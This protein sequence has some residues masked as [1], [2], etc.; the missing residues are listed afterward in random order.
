MRILLIVVAVFLASCGGEPVARNTGVYMLLDT[1]GTYRAE[2]EKA[3]QIIYYT[4]SRLGPAD[5]FAVARI[6]TGSAEC[7][8]VGEILRPIPFVEQGRPVADDLVEHLLGRNPSRLEI[9]RP[10]IAP[11]HPRTRR[12]SGVGFGELPSERHVVRNVEQVCTEEQRAGT[13]EVRVP[14][15]E[16][17]CHKR[18]VQVHPID[19]GPHGGQDVVLR[20]DGED[21]PASKRYRIR[22]WR[23]GVAG[24]QAT[25]DE[26]AHPFVGT[27]LCGCG[28]QGPT[29][30]D[31]GDDG[32]QYSLTERDHGTLAIL[33]ELLP[34][35]ACP[36]A[37]LGSTQIIDEKHETF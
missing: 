32:R 17:R 8:R 22:P 16:P 18:A 5:S 33:V 23:G 3:E 27:L 7:R 4:L 2:L 28:R 10:P 19:V 31:D 11:Q 15:D 12:Q 30:N 20:T 25:V 35:D 21:S 29:R 14:V 24:P 36:L 13:V 34:R 6:D 37:S 26:H 9:I 1:S